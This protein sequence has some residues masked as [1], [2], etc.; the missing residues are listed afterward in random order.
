MQGYINQAGH[1]LSLKFIDGETNEQLFE[2]KDKSWM[3][4]GQ[5]MTNGYVTDIVKN[6]IGMEDAPENLVVM[7]VAYYEKK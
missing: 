7:M 1:R 6:S 3:E 4:I 5:F 2:I